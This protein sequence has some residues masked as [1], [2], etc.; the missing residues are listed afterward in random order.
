MFRKCYYKVI[1][2]S[3]AGEIL[4]FKLYSAL[5]TCNAEFVISVFLTGVPWNLRAL[6][7]VSKGSVK[8]TK[9]AWDETCNHNS[10]WL[11]EY[12][13]FTGLLQKVG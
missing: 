5:S 11:C 2:K 6:Q 13:C 3:S 12:H 4:P 1:C 7:V 10:M 9:F 8:Q